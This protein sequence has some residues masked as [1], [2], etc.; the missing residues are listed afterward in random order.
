VRC[1][2]DKLPELLEIG[3]GRSYLHKCRS[4]RPDSAPFWGM[5]YIEKEGALQVKSGVYISDKLVRKHWGLG[6]LVYLVF[7]LSVFSYI[8]DSLGSNLNFT[9]NTPER[10][11]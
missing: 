3:R 1:V 7:D 6:L 9:C 8:A 5:K 4:A 10:G 2:G 11:T